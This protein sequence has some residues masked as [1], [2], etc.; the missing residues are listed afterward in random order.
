MSGIT[1]SFGKEV[2]T[3]SNSTNSLSIE[4]KKTLKSI[5][6]SSEENKLDVKGLV[7]IVSNKAPS[8]KVVEAVDK[9]IQA[10]SITKDS[11]K[12]Q[13]KENLVRFDPGQHA[14]LHEGHVIYVSKPD[15]K[16]DDLVIGI[17]KIANKS[18]AKGGFGKIYDVDLINSEE[19]VALKLSRKKLKNKDKNGQVLPLSEV[20]RKLHEEK[21][22]VK[23]HAAKEDL[24]REY[25]MM[26][27]IKKNASSTDGLNCDAY[28]LVT[29]KNQ[30]GFFTSKYGCDGVTFLNLQLSDEEVLYKLTKQLCQGFKTL[31]ELKILHRDMKLENTLFSFTPREDE[32]EVACVISDF[33]GA[34]FIEDLFKTTPYPKFNDVFGNGTKCNISYQITEDVKTKLKEIEKFDKES[35]GYKKI[36][37]E[38]A[39]LMILNDR[40]SF[41]VLLYKLWTGK[42]PPFSSYQRKDYMQFDKGK[43]KYEKEQVMTKIG[44]N[45]HDACGKLNLKKTNHIMQLIGGELELGLKV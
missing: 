45:I 18:F 16:E 28:A 40:F 26:K 31:G 21:G 17:A 4:S 19:S 34:C 25:E 14:F 7:K 20:D 24:I 33:G 8:I 10:L 5:S 3:S 12:E 38:I 27:F 37:S 6:P 15:N 44:Q 11:E 13:I 41:G 22:S 36:T 1:D 35:E 42:E 29:Y 2:W 9:L 30:C 23:G 32:Y 39:D 43:I